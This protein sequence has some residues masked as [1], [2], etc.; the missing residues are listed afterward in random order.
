MWSFDNVL[1]SLDD[2]LKAIEDGAIEKKITEAVDALD[3][4]V[5]KAPEK[6]EKVAD[7]PQKM[8]EG[9]ETKR[10][11]FQQTAANLQKQAQKTIDIIQR[12]E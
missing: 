1:K 6:L 3:K 7:A 4:V 5:E 12:P 10:E 9:M 11:T 8:L 2:T